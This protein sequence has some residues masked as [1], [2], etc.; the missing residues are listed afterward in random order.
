MTDYYTPTTEQVENGYAYDPEY[1]HYHPDDPGYHHA[2]R[3]AFRRW[4]ADHDAALIESLAERAES[5]FARGSW[6]LVR[7]SGD[8]LRSSAQQIREGKTA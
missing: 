2:N 3:R 7:G 8:W 5:E 4:L 6:A 1:E